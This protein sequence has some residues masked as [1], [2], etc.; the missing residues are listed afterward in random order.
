MSLWII[1]ALMDEFNMKA[2]TMDVYMDV[3]QFRDRN[4]TR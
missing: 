2:V 3:L 1:G 4:D